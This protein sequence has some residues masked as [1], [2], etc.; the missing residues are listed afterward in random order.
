MS[1]ITSTSN[2]AWV[3]IPKVTGNSKLRLFCFP[4]AGAR[5]HVFREW[6]GAF[7]NGIETC[8]VLLPGEDFRENCVPSPEELV[9]ML[10]SGIRP[11]LDRPF[12]FFG[13]SMGAVIA[14]EVLRSLQR[15]SGM[16]AVHLFV[17]ARVAPAL[18]SFTTM[19]HNLPRA[20]LIAQLK[21]L[22]GTPPEILESTEVLELLLPRLRADFQLNETYSYCPGA[23]LLCPI[24]AFG[25]AEDSHATAEEM[26]PW[27]NCTSAAFS[28]TLMP[29]D[30]FFLH[31]RQVELLENISASLATHL[32]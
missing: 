29:G 13:H 16:T 5:S 26:L 19:L 6:I 12:A 17:S 30:H 3:R 24:T 14:F 10:V 8:L 2:R 21:I 28:F 31:T 32:S 1:A 18:T 27:R 20:E 9:P 22:N 11:H 4:Y 25:G 15:D 23:P 7:S